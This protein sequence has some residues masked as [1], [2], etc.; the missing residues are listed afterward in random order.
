MRLATLI[1]TSILLWNSPLAAR[2]W[3]VNNVAGDDIKDGLSEVSTSA[4]SGP[5]RTIAK[6]LRGASRMDRIIIANTGAAYHESITVCGKHSGRPEAPFTIIGNGAVLD[7][8]TDVP[9]DDWE[10]YRGEVFRFQ[11]QR[12]PSQ[13]LFLGGKP[14]A[15]GGKIDAQ[16]RMQALQPLEWTYYEGYIYFRP[17]AGR[18]P[19]QY[20]LT[21]ASQ[22][23]GI[24]LYRVLNV[25]IQDL[26]I[27]GYQL[28]GINAHDSAFDVKL[29]GL[30]CRGNGRSGVSIGGASRVE[31]EACLV[32]DNGVA[33]VRT[34]GYSH[35]KLVNCT[36]LDN[37][38]P[39]LVKEDHSE[40][41]EFE[42]P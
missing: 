30:T 39:A 10:F 18:L 7:G 14:L 41:Q 27:Q 11:P 42:V 33:Q 26:T 40:V 29:V 8:S 34:E 20:D 4:E 17:E 28:D 32:G 38:A 36:L 25:E 1:L 3:F 24:T 5:V 9:D 31:L 12:M 16:G 15:R 37:L 6:A 19:Q 13:M 22:T 35:T 23:V 2:D 21:F